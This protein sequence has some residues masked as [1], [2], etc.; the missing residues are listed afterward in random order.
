MPPD[1]PW[2]PAASPATKPAAPVLPEAADV[3]T[4]PYMPEVP[5]SSMTG[6]PSV[7]MSE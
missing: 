2:L 7:A 6:A 3:P 4:S 5:V 1:R